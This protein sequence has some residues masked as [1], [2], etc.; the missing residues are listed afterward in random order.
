MGIEENRCK[1]FWQG[2]KEGVAGVGVLVH[3]KWIE[4]MIEVKR[5]NERILVLRVVVGNH[6]LSVV[7]VYIPHVDRP[8]DE[9]E[10]LYFQLR[11]VLLSFT[12]VKKLVL[13]LNGYVGAEADRFAEVRGG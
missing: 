2:C 7:S 12:S 9:R 13:D 1:I 3:Q 11:K 4:S 6:V 8:L 10:E 5:V